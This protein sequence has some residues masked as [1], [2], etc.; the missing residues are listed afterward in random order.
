MSRLKLWVR[1]GV[2]VPFWVGSKLLKR[3]SAR[4]LRILVYHTIAE[5][6]PR[7]DPYRMSVPPVLFAA[8]LGWLRQHGYAFVSLDK[9][10]EMLQGQGPI[11]EK[12]V[13]V[14]FDDGFRDTLTRAYPILQRSG[15]PAT[16]FVV[17]RYLNGRE[18]FPWL[19]NSGQHE[20][21]LTWEE[22][23][24]LA[25]SPI[26]CVGSHGWTHRRLSDLSIADQRREIEQSKSALEAGLG[27]SITWFAY[28]YGHR[29][30]FFGETIACLQHA[31]FKGACTNVM[32][33]NQAGDSSW[34]LKRTR[35]GW[36]DHL[37]RF[38]LK[39]AGAYDWV[40]RWQTRKIAVA[41]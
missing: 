20:C 32:G 26:I 35:I 39:M 5:L 16:V 28:P 22:L 14:T 8:H 21:P 3:A 25:S 40:D 24:F 30:S 7:D 34:T 4:G 31:G 41:T 1:D 38:R 36:E 27:K 19:H 10:L 12:V 6:R 18:P 23:Q 13:A 2:S 29:G 9:A 11:P 17:P 37:W 33:V 15:V